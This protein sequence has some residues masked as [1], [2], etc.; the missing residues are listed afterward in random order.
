MATE[1]M[2]PKKRGRPAT[3]VGKPVQVRFQPSD[4]SEIDAWIAAQDDNPSRPEA[5]RRLV[6]WGL[7]A[8]VL[9]K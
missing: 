9:R 6:Q 2:Q 8:T 3:G 7:K 5:V 4:L 1:K